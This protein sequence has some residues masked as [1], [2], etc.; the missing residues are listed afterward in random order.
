MRLEVAVKKAFWMM[1]GAA[2]RKSPRMFIDGLELFG[3]DL[4]HEK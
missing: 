3:L 1:A 4:T 2:A